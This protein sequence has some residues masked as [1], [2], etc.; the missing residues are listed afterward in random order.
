MKKTLPKCV[1][2]SVPSGRF[3]FEKEASHATSRQVM[4]ERLAAIEE[5]TAKLRRL[6]RY[7]V[8][9]I[10]WLYDGALSKRP[11]FAKFIGDVENC[12][13]EGGRQ[14]SRA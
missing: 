2:G 11:S 1:N 3:N 4:R 14:P 8:A 9:K 7:S 10:A 6:R 5:Q 13:R 12:S